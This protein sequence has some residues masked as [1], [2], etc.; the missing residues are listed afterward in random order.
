VLE[1][2]SCMNKQDRGRIQ[3][4]SNGPYINDV[5]KGEYSENIDCEFVLVDSVLT[6]VKRAR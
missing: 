5:L 1:A 3:F 4:R 2:P 6:Y